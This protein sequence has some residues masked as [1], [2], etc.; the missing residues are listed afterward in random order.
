MKEGSIILAPIPQSNGEIKNRPCLILREMPKYRDFLVCGISTQLKQY[1][2]DFDQIISPTD[3]DFQFS[4]LM[5]Q[6]VIRL[7]FLTVIFNKNIIGKIG[8]ISS[9]RHQ[10]LLENLSQYLF[11]S[12]QGIQ[13]S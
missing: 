8:D 5:S 1:I 2:P 13:R 12:Q 10:R 6:S 4:G 11:N 3:E 7:S 9:I